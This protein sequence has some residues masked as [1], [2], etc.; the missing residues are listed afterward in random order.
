MKF[1]WKKEKKQYVLYGE[2]QAVAVIDA[3]TGC[4]D[5]FEEIGEGAFRW[6]RKASRP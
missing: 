3:M 6:V 5:S 2:D 1:A 4:E